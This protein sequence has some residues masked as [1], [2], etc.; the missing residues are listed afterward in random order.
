[1]SINQESLKRTYANYHVGLKILLRKDNDFFFL[2]TPSGKHFD[3]PGGRIDNVEHNIPLAEII[4]REVGEELGEEIKYKI[5]KPIFQFRRHFEDNGQHIF[6]T[7][8]EAEYLSGDIQLSSEHS[9]YEWLNPKTAVLKESD[10]FGE[11][12]FLAV[13]N[14][15]DNLV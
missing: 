12:E 11:E 2:R 15:F 3:L 4:E 10:F 6:L 5:G 13:K 8:Y 14:Y 9:K 7:V 1:M